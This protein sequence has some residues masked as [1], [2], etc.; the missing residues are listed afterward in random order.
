MA[1]QVSQYKR[2]FSTFN[3]RGKPFPANDYGRGKSSYQGSQACSSGGRF[4]APRQCT[5]CGT[6]NHTID[7]CFLIHGL[8]PSFK[9][10]RVHNVTTEDQAES[11]SSTLGVSQEQIHGLLALLSQCN[12]TTTY[13]TDLV[14]SDTILRSEV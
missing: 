11:H 9:S 3:G 13:S 5:Q 2:S 8:P 7:T 10:K 4:D 12:P 6:T 1:A 14:R